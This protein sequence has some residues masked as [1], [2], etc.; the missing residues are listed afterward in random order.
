MAG[1][2]GSSIYAIGGFVG[3]FCLASREMWGRLV[4]GKV[5]D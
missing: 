1:Q 2:A 5:E 3:D 4:F